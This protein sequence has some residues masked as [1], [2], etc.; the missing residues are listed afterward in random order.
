MEYFKD[1]HY[2]VTGGSSGIGLAIARSLSEQG[3]EVCIVGRRQEALHAAVADLGG[4]LWSVQ[5]DVGDEHL[6]EALAEAVGDRWTSLD[7][8]VNNAGVA[9]MADLE[10]T[11]PETWDQCFRINARGPFLVTRA[12][13][14]LLRA[15]ESPSIVNIS[16]TLAEKAIPGMVAYNSAKAA[17]NQMT[18]SIALEL[19]PKI[20]VNAI[21][22]AV[23][24]TPIH[25]SR[26]M[27]PGEVKGMGR[28]HPLNRVGQ[29]EDIAEMTV[30]LLSDAASW[31]TGAIIPVDG[32]MM[33]T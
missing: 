9:P 11:D 1:K 32:G 28:I 13:L 8:L 15:A 5:C 18:R 17:L 33:A 25:S 31:M 16:S 27:S 7:G 22:P 3:A 23:V 19:A 10:G 24:D 2:V 29:P 20:R 12:L 26:G 21:M 14:G 4:G 6:V 30:F